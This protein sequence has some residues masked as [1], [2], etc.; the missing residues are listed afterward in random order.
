MLPEE[1]LFDCLNNSNPIL[2]LGAG[3]TYMALNHKNKMIELASKLAENIFKKFYEDTRPIGVSEDYIKGVRK[4]ELKDLCTTIKQESEER[5]ELLY[6]FLVDTF[7]GAHPDPVKNF[8][9]LIQE[10]NW[11]KIYTLNIDD[12]VENIYLSEGKPILVQNESEIKNNEEDLLQ[13]YKL[14]G[15]VNKRENGF[16]FSSDEYTSMIENAD[17]KLKEFANDYY[18]NDVIFVGTELDEDDVSY[19]LNNYLLSGYKHNKRCFYVSPSV[20]PK[21]LS[22]IQSDPNSYIVNWDT[23]KFLTQMFG[24]VEKKNIE[25]ENLGHLKDRGLIIVDEKLK[26]KSKYYT[27]VLYTGYAPFFEDIL[28]GWDIM[29]PKY[30][31]Q[32][33]K[34]LDL[35]TSTLIALYGKAYV[36]KT[37]VAKRMVVDL[38][39]QGFVALEFRMENS[40]DFAML[41]R[42]IQSYAEGVRFAILVEDAAQ[43]YKRLFEFLEN[44][45]LKEYLIVFITTSNVL[46]H[47]SK[48]HELLLHS[49]KELCVKPDLTYRFSIN[50]Y[51]K[52]SEKNRLGILSKFA[53]TKKSTVNFI[54]QQ[55]DIINLL[56]TLTHGKGF[57][58]YFEELIENISAPKEYF[59]LFYTVAIFS[60]LQIEG[61]PCELITNIHK[62]I[63]KGELIKHFGELLYFTERD[64]FVKLRC[65]ILVENIVFS[66]FNGMQI[67]QLITPNVMY[68]KGLFNEETENIWSDYFHILTKASFLHKRLKISYDD[69]RN[70]YIDLEGAFS[71]IS[72]YW[73][74]RA[75]LEQHAKKFEDAEIFIN[76]AKKIRPDSYQAQHAM[77]K[78]RMERAMQELDSMSYSIA[79]YM[80]EEGERN[81]VDL[82]NNPRYSRSFCYSVHA[83]LDMKMKYCDK[84]HAG[85]DKDEAKCFAEWIL[86]GLKLSND[87]Y[88][89]DIKNRFIKFA[90]KLGFYDSVYNLCSYHYKASSIVRED[91]D[92]YLE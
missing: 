73:M 1:M 23:E 38:Y 33:N 48:R 6:D 29:Y 44:E 72:Y 57:Q 78:N 76:N 88:M 47:T 60:S 90:E 86:Q 58:E 43:M 91:N 32:K 63:K 84:T 42:Y 14:H 34:L 46:H 66:K 74:Q 67:L 65:G 18:K 22:K 35:K 13:L 49:Y 62:K 10:Y 19:I 9:K 15:C 83:Y 36:G 81:I 2:F 69:L 45:E 31:E 50:A 55:K 27:P 77:A 5:K 28:D 4:Y 61:Y 59:D 20:K 30:E 68:L 64:R 26:N 16:I 12:L 54:K 92:E 11:K 51:E 8:H 24:N 21:L 79:A 80:F 85:I 37:C 87:K 52:L 7:K 75:I 41:M 17:F 3:Y 25:E 40:M 82:I 39:T 56:Y 70:F 71:N 53:D 89:N